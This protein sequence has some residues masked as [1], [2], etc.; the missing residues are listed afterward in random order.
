MIYVSEC[1]LAA[2]LT[3]DGTVFVDSLYGPHRI[4]ALVV[5]VVGLLLVTFE[6]TS[7]AYFVIEIDQIAIRPL[8]PSH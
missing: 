6:N 1:I 4:I 2:W 8:S 7:L 3:V 5:S